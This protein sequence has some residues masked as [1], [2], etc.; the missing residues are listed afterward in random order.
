VKGRPP[1]DP[2]PPAPEGLCAL[3]DQ[4]RRDGVS[5]VDNLPFYHEAPGN[6]AVLLVHGF[7]ATP[8]EMRAIGQHLVGAGFTV[9]GV[10]LP[11][12]GTTPE[13]LA[14]TSRQQWLQAVVEGFALLSAQG[15]R[16]YGL[17]QSTGALLLICAARQLPLAGLVL[18]S[19]FLRLRHPLAPLAGL[20]RHLYPF[21]HRR[22]DPALAPYYYERRPLLAIAQLVRLLRQ[23]RRLLPKTTTPV[24]LLSGAG[25]RTADPDSAIEFFHRLAGYP[26]RL[27]LFG[28]D[29]PHI[30]STA[31]NPRQQEVFALTVDFLRHL[32]E[33]GAP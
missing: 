20:L 4:A 16:V 27:C 31:E 19:P 32:E 30:L 11:G 23:V 9:L 7:S 29:V 18:L 26:R 3:L 21:Q 10:R 6:A 2:I 13:A 33:R 8:W 15:K 25:D 5:S 14:V 1:V 22:I 17:G 24:L 28:P 12:H